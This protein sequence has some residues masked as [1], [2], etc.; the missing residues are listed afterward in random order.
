MGWRGDRGDEAIERAR[1]ARLSLVAARTPMIYYFKLARRHGQPDRASATSAP[2]ELSK[3][4]I[5]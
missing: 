5:A 1:S 3:R 4:V 2:I